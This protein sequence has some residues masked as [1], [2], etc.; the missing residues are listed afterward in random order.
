MHDGCLLDAMLNYKLSRRCITCVFTV[1]V[2]L[3]SGCA[4]G[5]QLEQYPRRQIDRP[6]TLPKGVDNWQTVLG[7]QHSSDQW[8]DTNSSAI[9]NPLT[10]Q[11]SLSD[12]WNIVWA[13]IPLAVLHQFSKTDTNMMGA[14]FAMGFV[15]SSVNG[16]DLRPS[17][18]F[19]ERH[20]FTEFLAL[21]IIPSVTPRIPFQA[22]QSFDW[23]GGIALQP[24]FQVTDTL[25]FQPGMILNV[26][27]GESPQDS[28][29][30]SNEIFPPYTTQ[31]TLPLS[32]HLG[33]SASRRWD[34]NAGYTYY[35]IG[36][37][38]G[39][40]NHV[41]TITAIYYW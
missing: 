15:Y 22:G 39:F 29:Y 4:S 23:L 25:A 6:Y 24:L 10:W 35:G 37:G 11:Q 3:F 33:W 28:Y 2:S 13:P 8:G 20:N 27:R 12:D 26:E 34:L 7:E 9:V 40:T 36:Y 32:A 5:P 14:G 1:L 17:L 31:V 30:T 16:F 38:A 18:S 41:G 19:T 21:D